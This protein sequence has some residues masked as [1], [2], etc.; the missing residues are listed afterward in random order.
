MSGRGQPAPVRALLRAGLRVV[1]RL[2]RAWWFLTRPP[3]RGVQLVVLRANEVL[4]VRH[5]YGD[6]RRW[7]LPG[8]GIKRGEAPFDAARRELREELALEP[9]DWRRLGEVATRIDHRVGKLSCFVAHV[10]G[11][12]QTPD[13]V[14]ILEARWFAHDALPARRGDHVAQIVRIAVATDARAER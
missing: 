13:D 11:D 3:L 7:E 9:T 4:L 12:G 8:G 2:L 10:A 6:R 5:S 14:E 1:Y